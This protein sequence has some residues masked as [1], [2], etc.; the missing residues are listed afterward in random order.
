MFLRH[1]VC[2]LLGSR[3]WCSQGVSTE[4]TK[5]Q[6]VQNWPTPSCVKEVRRF[7]GLAGYYRKFV[8]NFGVLSRPLTNLLK[9]GTIFL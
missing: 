6:A 7:L 5:I 1:S 2:Q 4:Q 8:R 3:H 9:K